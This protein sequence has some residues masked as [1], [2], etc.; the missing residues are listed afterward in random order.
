[1]YGELISGANICMHLIS[2]AIAIQ[3]NGGGPLTSPVC[4]N[5]LQTV[6]W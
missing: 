1:M 2:D 4:L 3:S 6:G 5:G